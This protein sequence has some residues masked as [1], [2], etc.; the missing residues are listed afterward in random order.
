MSRVVL[1][2]AGPGVEVVT[3]LG[4]KLPAAPGMSLIAGE[5]ILVPDGSTAKVVL[6]PNS[7]N[8]KPIKALLTPGTE[9]TVGQIQNV[10]QKDLLGLDVVTGD[11]LIE[12]ALLAPGEQPEGVMLVKKAPPASVYGGLFPWLLGAGAI[13]AL[14]SGG[15]GGDDAPPP[16]V[17]PTDPVTP[18]PPPPPPVTPPVIIDPPAPLPPQ[19]LIDPT[20]ELVGGLTGGPSGSAL[21]SV[22]T[23]IA[24][25]L[26]SGL[27]PIVGGPFVTDTPG[28]L[29]GTDA[30]LAGLIDA[31]DQGLPDGLTPSLTPL[32]TQTDFLTDALEN[33]ANNEQSAGLLVP[34]LQT[35]GAMSDMTIPALTEAATLPLLVTLTQPLREASASSG[36]GNLTSP[37]VLPDNGLEDLTGLLGNLGSLPISSLP[38][39][40]Q[41]GSP[42]AFL[43]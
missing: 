12:D 42:L 23:P 15:G 28:A 14:A 1:D 33:L 8:A 10:N 40:P 30:G 24:D 19:G 16:P 2:A 18:T 26:N 34:V 35:L 21:D 41:L 3:A 7:P 37:I 25:N 31:L 13:G 39:A 17:T 6:V 27:E 22:L 11:V 9:V 36:L 4:N 38:A 5:K 32:V 43:G 20:V 29:D